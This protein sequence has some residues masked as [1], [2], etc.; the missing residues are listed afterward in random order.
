MNVIDNSQL[1]N[2]L[3]VKEKTLKKFSNH[4]LLESVLDFVTQF[5]LRTD[6]EKLTAGGLYSLERAYHML[7]IPD[8]CEITKFYK[9]IEEYD[10]IGRN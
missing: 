6:D 1:I 8:P 9:I 2:I 5:S 7:G 3:K 4:E 10:D